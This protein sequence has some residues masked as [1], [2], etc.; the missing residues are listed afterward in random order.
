MQFAHYLDMT[1]NAY[2][3]TPFDETQLEAAKQALPLCL[4]VLRACQTNSSACVDV[5]DMETGGSTCG[6]VVKTLGSA[7]RNVYDIRTTCYES[8]YLDCY[9]A[10][11]ITKYLNLPAVQ[12]YLNISQTS[13]VWQECS[14]HVAAGFAGDRGKNFAPYIEDLLNDDALRILFYY[15]DAD[16]MCN[17]IGGKAW[18]SQLEWKHQAE[19]NAAPDRAFEVAVG[20][21]SQNQPVLE[22]A[23]SVK[24]FQDR[25]TYLRVFNAGHLVPRN[26]PLVALE[27]LRRFLR[28]EQL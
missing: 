8:N 14:A 17:W 18:V 19:F 7:N 13:P 5:F 24:S 11:D 12:T 9:S 28:S 25:L 16:L 22:S 23:G 6:L 27:M 26:Q 21:D 15:G 10:T 4:D 20:A 1:D 3:I 2:N